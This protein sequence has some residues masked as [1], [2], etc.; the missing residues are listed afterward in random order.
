MPVGEVEL[1]IEQDLDATQGFLGVTVATDRHERGLDRQVDGAH[2]V[3]EEHR[4]AF[5]HRDEHGLSPHIVPGDR[6]AELC[7]PAA[8]VL[9]SVQDACDLRHRAGG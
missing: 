4:A 8:N 9:A 3:G 7:H 6:A 5:Q 2:K 1:D